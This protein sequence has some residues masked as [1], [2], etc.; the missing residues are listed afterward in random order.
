MCEGDCM[1]RGG[2]SGKPRAR[3]PAWDSAHEGTERI[4]L[5]PSYPSLGS[6]DP[7]DACARRDG[8]ARDPRSRLI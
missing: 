8:N 1:P 4:A 7:S 2:W 6:N 5:T 3:P